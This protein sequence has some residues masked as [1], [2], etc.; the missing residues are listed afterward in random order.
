M[1][2]S[3]QNQIASLFECDPESGV[4]ILQN[5]CAHC[6]NRGY[7][8]DYDANHVCPRCGGSGFKRT[9][10][11]QKVLDLMRTNFVVLM[12]EMVDGEMARR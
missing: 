3:G 7:T 6:K 5:E 12:R 9:E 11:G 4:P 1:D 8:R 2:A 10:F